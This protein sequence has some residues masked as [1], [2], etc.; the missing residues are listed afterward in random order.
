MHQKITQQI[1][2]LSSSVRLTP[3]TKNNLIT[4]YSEKIFSLII[5]RLILFRI[6][7]FPIIVITIYNKKIVFLWKFE[8]KI[9]NKILN[10]F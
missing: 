9:F 4:K 3:P 10:E 2:L 7:T 8:R 1:F 5:I 6:D